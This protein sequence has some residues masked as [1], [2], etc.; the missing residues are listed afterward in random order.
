MQIAKESAQLTHS[1]ALGYNG[2]ILETCA[3][4][5]ALHADPLTFT[6]KEYE[7]KL[8]GIMASQEQP[9]RGGDGSD[10][11]DSDGDGSDDDSD[12]D[13]VSGPKLKR[14]RYVCTLL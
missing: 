12:E 2:A 13:E 4:H 9:P 11:S 14:L 5:L 3:I 1:N 10:D 6:A 7:D 8:L